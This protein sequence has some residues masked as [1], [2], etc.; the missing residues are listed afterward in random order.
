MGFA[1]QINQ[2]YA[3]FTRTA[4]Q[5]FQ[6][7]G[8]DQTVQIFP[9]KLVVGDQ[10]LLEIPLSSRVTSFEAFQDL[11]KGIIT[12]YIKEKVYWRYTISTKPDGIQIFFERGKEGFKK[13]YFLPSVVK[14]PETLEL[15]SCGVYKKQEWEKILRRSD[16]KEILPLFFLASQ[17]YKGKPREEKELVEGFFNDFTG[18]LCPKKTALSHESLRE[19]FVVFDPHLHLLP[20]VLTDCGR[21]KNLHAGKALVDLEWRSWKLQKA[22]VLPTEDLTF[23]VPNPFKSCRLRLNAKDRGR[24]LKKGQILTFEKGI[25]V[26]LDRFEK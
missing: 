19:F 22:V 12:V 5:F 1:I 15:V 16:L 13:D 25:K 18:I 11:K 7:F 2:L 10:F 17:W 3:P 6:L 26:F 4:G 24:V 14:K 9:E 20:K 23:S 8:T 21:A